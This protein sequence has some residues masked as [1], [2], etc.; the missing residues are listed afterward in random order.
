M[1]LA[2]ANN[3]T[4]EAL[5]RL[6]AAAIENGPAAPL[7]VERSGAFG[8][9]LLCGQ[10]PGFGCHSSTACGVLAISKAFGKSD[11]SIPEIARPRKSTQLVARQFALR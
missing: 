3:V 2:L 5:F 10:F 8:P 1:S 6:L 9:N 11:P 4:P 7:P